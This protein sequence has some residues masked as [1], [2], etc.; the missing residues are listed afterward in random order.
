M[1]RPNSGYRLRTRS[2]NRLRTYGG[3]PTGLTIVSDTFTGPNGTVLTAHIT[4]SGHTWTAHDGSA[5]IQSNRVVFTGGGIR[6]LHTLQAGRSNG[7]ASI[8][9]V[10]ALQKIYLAGRFLNTSNYW[11]AHYAT[12]GGA[13]VEL[14]E[15]NGGVETQRGTVSLTLNANDSL[16]LEMRGTA[17]SVGR[18]STTF[19]S[20]VSSFNLTATRWGLGAD[21][22]SNA[23]DNYLFVS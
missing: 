14:Y 11:Y 2:P 23:F 20:H 3:D 4:D 1:P 15:V 10:N 13:V 17:I 9:C 21:N 6:N 19:I 12:D 18:N 22:G 8:V 7:K 5:E 16:W